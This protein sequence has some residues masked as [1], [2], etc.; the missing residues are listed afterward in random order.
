MI[1]RR[2]QAGKE[3][4]GPAAK[5]GSMPVKQLFNK[6]LQH[7]QP[8][9]L[10]DVETLYFQVLTVEPR[11]CQQPASTRDRYL[12]LGHHDE[13]LSMMLKV[14]SIQPE[15]ASYNNNLGNMLRNKGDPTRRP[16]ACVRGSRSSRTTRKHTTILALCAQPSALNGI[17]PRHTT[18]WAMP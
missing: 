11:Q 8:G 14:I 7:H 16:P 18:T 6:A 15:V 3:P 10:A 17:S 1:R 9:R 4:G 13:A 12:L 5:R 2:R